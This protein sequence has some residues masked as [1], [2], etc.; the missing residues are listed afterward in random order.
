M[1]NLFVL[2]AVAAGTIV[3]PAQV[4]NV[5][6]PEKVVSGATQAVI[7]PDGRYVVTVADTEISKVNLKD[8]KRER[9]A[10]GNGLYG[11]TISGD[12]ATVAFCRPSFSEDH[13]RHVSLE[14][15]NTASGARKV[16]VAPTRTLNTGVAF[17]GNTVNAVSDGRR[18]TANIVGSAVHTAPVAS[19]SYGHLVITDTDGNSRNLDPQGPG[20]YLW[21]QIS[22]DG[23]RVVYRLSGEGTF[24]CRLDGSDV[25]P[26]GQ[27]LLAA[28]W[29]GNDL[30]VGMTQT[31]DTYRVT[32]SALVAVDP[33]DGSSQ[34][35]TATPMGAAF[36]SATADG[37]KVAFTTLSGDVYIMNI[38]KRP[39]K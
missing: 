38:S 31:D 2:L 22:P 34:Q 12:G 18:R 1:K 4:V 36:P 35:I 21:P 32:S 17:V 5:G 33:A 8:L 24:T 13:L 28:V 30:L 39:V 9:L 26:A 10:E 19:I 7:S 14:T 6:S 3:S 37:K 29:A 20:S 11:V 27:E 25:R 23:Q 15:V 16:V